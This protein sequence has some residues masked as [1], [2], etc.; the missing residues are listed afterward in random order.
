MTDANKNK[1][2]YT[3]N[4]PF[5]RITSSSDPLT[6]VSSSYTATT[7]ETILNVGSSAVDTLTTVDGLGRV[8]TS[9]QRQGPASANFNTVS[10][11]YDADGRLATVSMPCSTTAGATCGTIAKSYSYDGLN[12]ITN[13]QNPGTTGY[14][15]YAYTG[16]DVLQTVGP[17]ASGASL[18]E[19]QY[20][21]DA[22]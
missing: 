14:M 13:I 5:W 21:Y 16:Q 11:S 1:T 19:R 8:L 18:K 17:V 9:Q 3:Y 10:R 12:R 15:S 22:L 2:T 20:E 7:S 4:D 6:G